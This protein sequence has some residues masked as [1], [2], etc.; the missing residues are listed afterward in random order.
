MQ[1]ETPQ[2]EEARRNDDED[3]S[4]KCRDGVICNNN[5]LVQKTGQTC[6]ACAAYRSFRNLPHKNS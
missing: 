1:E 3:L 5:G 2:T 6:G 4:T